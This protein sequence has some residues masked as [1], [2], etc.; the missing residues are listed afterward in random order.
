MI[1]STAMAHRRH[2]GR[3]AAP[4]VLSAEDRAKFEAALRPAKAERRIVL[5]AQAVLLMADGVP[6]ADIAMLLG[7]E[8]STVCRFRRRFSGP[9]PADRLA[10][11]PRSGR[12]PSLSRPQTA[13]K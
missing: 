12:P 11:A 2:P 3:R 1:D 7:I 5:R 9:N 13:P 4:V 6:G 8:E 10:D